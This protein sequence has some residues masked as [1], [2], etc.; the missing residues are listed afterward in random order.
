MKLLNQY[1]K[2]PNKLEIKHMVLIELILLVK[3]KMV[4]L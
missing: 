4:L 2:Y 1:L 3:I